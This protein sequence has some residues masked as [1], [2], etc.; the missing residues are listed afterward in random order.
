MTAEGQKID[1]D[2]P[3][4]GFDAVGGG[5]SES[6][7]RTKA[8]RTVGLATTLILPLVLG[9]TPAPQ[10]ITISA[11]A[12]QPNQAVEKLLAYQQNDASMAQPVVG[13]SNA[14]GAADKAVDQAR[15]RL[16]IVNDAMKGMQAQDDQQ[17]NTANV[18][19]PVVAS[20][21]TML[22][23][24]LGSQ[25]TALQQTSSY[26]YSFGGGKGA[27]SKS[28]RDQT[29]GYTLSAGPNDAATVAMT[30]GMPSGP[31][32]NGGTQSSRQLSGANFD[33]VSSSLGGVNGINISDINR[34]KNDAM[35][36][37]PA[38][39]KIFE[40]D[41]STTYRAQRLEIPKASPSIA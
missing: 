9:F 23:A 10:N 35:S 17:N 31:A 33:Y 15:T 22:G 38:S 18:P 3:L 32:M 39:K 36:V 30:A 8:D 21:T 24:G 40:Q 27:E 6:T 11:S 13:A 14:A 7:T 19:M 28:S 5:G 29:P 12:P 41:P 4:D 2:H 25:V 37:L 20:S 34:F 16:N 26:S 1:M